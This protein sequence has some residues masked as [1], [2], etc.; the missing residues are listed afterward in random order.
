MACPPLPSF[1]AAI[2][3]NLLKNSRPVISLR[4][5]AQIESP[6]SEAVKRSVVTGA[7]I[8]RKLFGLLKGLLFQQYRAVSGQSALTG[9]TV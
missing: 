6:Y 9:Q 7:V 4:M 2:G 8:R 5:E 3:H 1:W